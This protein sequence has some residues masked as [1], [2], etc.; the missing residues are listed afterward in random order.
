MRIGTSQKSWLIGICLFL[1]IGM[2]LVWAGNRESLPGESTAFRE[3]RQVLASGK[4][5]L[6]GQ[7]VGMIGFYG[8]TQPPQWLVLTDGGKD[9]ATFLEYVIRDG[10]IRSQRKVRR[11]KGQ[12]LPEKSIDISELKVDSHEASRIAGDLAAEFGAEFSTIHYQLRCRDGG[13]EPV[14]VISLIGRYQVSVGSH[15]I[16]ALTGEVIDSRWYVTPRKKERPAA[17]EITSAER[18][19][20]LVEPIPFREGAE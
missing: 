20:R 18:K 9:S 15:Y 11:L 6:Q 13:S 17:L 7:V 5:G 8:D 2:G 19:V 16:S 1:A 3:L 14:W 12:D 4:G 10:E